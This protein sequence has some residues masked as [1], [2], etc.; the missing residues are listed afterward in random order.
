MEIFGILKL[1]ELIKEIVFLFVVLFKYIEL[2]LFLVVVV[3]VSEC[4]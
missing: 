3:I 2:R 1:N 4:I